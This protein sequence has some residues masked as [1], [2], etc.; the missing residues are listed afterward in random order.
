MRPVF[1]FPLAAALLAARP[2]LVSAQAPATVPADAATVRGTVRD[3]AGTPVAQA[4]VVVRHEAD[5]AT[6]GALTD[7]QGAFALDGLAAGV[8]TLRVQRAG[9]RAETRSGLALAAGEARS[10]TVRLAGEA[11]TLAAVTVQAA[12]RY[13]APA[14]AAS[15]RLDAPL[16]DLPQSVHVVTADY[17]EDQTVNRLEDVFRNVSGVNAFSGYQD[18]AVRGFRTS[19]VLWNGVRGNPYNFFA[20]PKVTDV[21]RI[22]V[23]KGPASVLY[24]AL[25]PGGLINVVPKR[26]S[27][28]ARRELL[29]TYGSFGRTQA[30]LDATGAVLGGGER[31]LYRLT[32]DGER[33]GSFRDFQR[34]RTV[35]VAPSLAW[36]PSA[37]TRV[38][39]RAEYL[40]DAR[41][42]QRDRGIAAPSGDV[43]ALGL[44]WT[45]NEPGD[46][47]R[48]RGRSAQLDL[49]Q[50]LGGAWRLTSALRWARSDYDNAYHE[51]RGFATTAGRLVMRRQ[52]RDQQFDQEQRAADLRVTGALRGLGLAHTLVVGGDFLDSEGRTASRNANAVPALD[53][54]APRYGA[55]DPS[56][57]ATTL[58]VTAERLRRGGAYAQDLVTVRPDLKV[59]VGARVD[60][61]DD[62]TDNVTPGNTAPATRF[63][64]GALTLRGGLVYQP[65]A[66]LSL[67]GSY[68][69]GFLP[70]GPAE[71]QQLRGG[72]FAPEETTQFEGGAKAEWLGGR[73]ST[74]LAGYRIRKAN[75][76][77]PLAVGSD[78]LR[79]AGVIRSQGV[80]L[81]AMGSLTRGWSLVA[82]YAY[83]DAAV[84]AGRSANPLD[85]QVPN[86]PRH[87]AG[88]WS[89]VELTALPL[90]GL[91]LGGGVRYVGRRDTFDAT[92]LPAYGV[93]DAALYYTA[94]PVGLTLTVQNV[95]DARHFVG[96]YYDRTLFPGAPRTARLTVRTR[97]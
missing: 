58:G 30:T 15:T 76:L 90:R 6:R 41:D 9:F 10:L 72:P 64:D 34:L 26:P 32:A 92:D 14:A 84:V 29:L 55:A 68:S 71:Q 86:A 78:S 25:D 62:A 82:N 27:A 43:D 40:D 38:T 95:T 59:L 63:A 24:G 11:A 48:N 20:A 94:G 46:R 97:F 66:A 57:Y 74:T 83:N 17:L 88:L 61:F 52:F 49:D 70:Q 8:Y 39:A 22:E 33:A 35:Q 37:A 36:Q 5:G 73:L 89:R 60:R 12:R 96:G 93:G 51:P 47:A 85:N 65:T 13:A 4:Q 31:L 81:D 53:V 91:A 80:E 1:L 54:F 50:R 67:Y 16:R 79:S 23:L 77:V 18:F 3:S 56:A 75:Q 44:G 21:E 7:A 28:D 69:E 87:S 19:Q 45:A 2:L 42:G